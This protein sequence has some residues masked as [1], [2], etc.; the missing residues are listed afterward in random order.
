MPRP[1][2]HAAPLPLVGW[3]LVTTRRL[4][5]PIDQESWLIIDCTI[6]ETALFEI[7]LCIMVYITRGLRASAYPH[8]CHTFPP[9]HARVGIPLAPLSNRKHVL[10]RALFVVKTIFWKQNRL[11]STKMISFNYEWSW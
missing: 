10:V 9:E 5:A 6:I 8:V 2:L 7:D 3:A 1:E 11:S 4:H